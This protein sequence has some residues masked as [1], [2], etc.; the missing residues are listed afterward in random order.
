MR[1]GRP[2]RVRVATVSGTE[3]TVKV[4]GDSFVFAWNGE[5]MAETF[6]Y[7]FELFQESLGVR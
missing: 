3:L 4:D 1:K 6:V 2:P 5:P 7:V